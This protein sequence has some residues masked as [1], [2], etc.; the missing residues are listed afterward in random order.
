M[1]KKDGLKIFTKFIE[2]SL[3]ELL[4]VFAAFVV[5]II[6]NQIHRLY[7]ANLISIDAATF[8]GTFLSGFTHWLSSLYSSREFS[9]VAVYVFWLLIAALVYLMAFRLTKNAN[10]IT[11]DFKIRH[12]VWPIGTD[13]NNPIKKYLEQFGIKFVTLI[14]VFLYLIKLSPPLVN[15]WNHHYISTG[16]SIHALLV[17]LILLVFLMLYVHGLVILIRIFLLRLRIVNFK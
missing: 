10:E 12:Y 9:T 4:S 16:Y 1:Y 8:K 11:E 3:L 7:S 5:L 15:W 17:D 14:T 2:P 6:A 13:R